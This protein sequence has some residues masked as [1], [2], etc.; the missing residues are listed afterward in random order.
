MK[1]YIHNSTIINADTNEHMQVTLKKVS[2]DYFSDQ[3]YDLG[4]YDH[5]DYEIYADG[6]KVGTLDLVDQFN[7]D[8]KALLNI[9]NHYHTFWLY[10]HIY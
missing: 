9:L 10:Y 8:L 5:H 6:I 1:L 4:I 7:D 2:S 3:A